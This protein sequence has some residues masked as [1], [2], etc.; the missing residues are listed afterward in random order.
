[1]EAP[2]ASLRR[3][4]RGGGTHRHIDN[5]L[6]P[7]S[8]SSVSF[9]F[10]IHSHLL[11]SQPKHLFKIVNPTRILRQLSKMSAPAFDP[12]NMIVRATCQL[13]PSCYAIASTCELI[14]VLT[15]SRSTGTS[16]PRVS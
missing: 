16:A 3:I 9:L 14:D 2:S 15:L 10:F 4:P 5:P 1:M 7:I 8:T 11:L 6:H 13:T 12:K